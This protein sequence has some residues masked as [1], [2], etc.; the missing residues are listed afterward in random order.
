[1]EFTSKCFFCIVWFK[2]SRAT[3]IMDASVW[4]SAAMPGPRWVT[5]WLTRSKFCTAS[6][7]FTGLSNEEWLRLAQCATHSWL[8]NLDLQTKNVKSSCNSERTL[9]T[10]FGHHMAKSMCNCTFSRCCGEMF[11]NAGRRKEGGERRTTQGEMAAPHPNHLP[12][13]EEDECSTTHTDKGRAPF[14]FTFISIVTFQTEGGTAPPP[15]GRV[16]RSTTH[17][18]RERQQHEFSAL[19]L[20]KHLFSSR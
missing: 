1:M 7:F 11:V 15:C 4:V 2:S 9:L 20:R 19:T 17:K 8:H 13:G 10:C 14:Y 18:G 16:Q 12:Q 5:P 3:N 6:R